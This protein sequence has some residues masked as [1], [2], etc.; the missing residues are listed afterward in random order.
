MITYYEERKLIDV[1]RAM[2]DDEALI[3]L[4]IFLLEKG[5]YPEFIKDLNPEDIESI[6][7]PH[8]AMNMVPLECTENVGKII[9]D[10]M[11][12]NACPFRSIYGC[13]G[14]DRDKLQCHSRWT[15]WFKST[16]YKM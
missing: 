11:D 6:S 16:L 7:C 1:A 5:L 4:R 3:F 13:S 10:N 14:T 2:T 8:P 9:S 15:R 12:C